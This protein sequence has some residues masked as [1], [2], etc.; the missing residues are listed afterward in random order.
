MTNYI[1]ITSQFHQLNLIRT[2]SPIPVQYKPLNFEFITKPQIDQINHHR[3]GIQQ[4]SNKTHWS[5]SQN[6]AWNIKIPKICIVR[7]Y[8]FNAWK[9][10]CK[11][12][13]K[14]KRKGIMGIPALGEENL[15]KNLAKNDKKLRIVLV[16]IG[17]RKRSLK[18]FWKSVLN[19]SNLAFKKAYLRFSINRKSVLIDQNRK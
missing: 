7:K 10:A 18:I 4:Y 6:K 5:I 15:T 1:N 14:W 16:R 3:S 9:N 12:K 11:T 19:K 2:K 17:E 8:P 13:N